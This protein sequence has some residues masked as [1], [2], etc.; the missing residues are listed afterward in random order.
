MIG[1]YVEELD[2][3]LRDQPAEDALADTAHW[4]GAG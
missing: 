1:M 2:S 3:F 4:L